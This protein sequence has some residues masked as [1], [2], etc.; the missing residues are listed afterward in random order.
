[1]SI[2]LSKVVFLPFGYLI[3]LWRWKV[4]SGEITSQN[5]NREWWNHRL[6]YQG[7]CPPVQRTEQ[8]FDAGA[9]YHIVANSPYMR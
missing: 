2:A 4:F 7:V 9:K 8:D 3:D 6:E 1:M 5:L